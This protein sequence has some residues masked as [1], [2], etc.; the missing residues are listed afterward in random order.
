MKKIILILLALFI[1]TGCSKQEEIENPIVTMTIKDYGDVIIELYPDKAYNTV[2]NF[3]NLTEDG[4]YDNNT[5]HRLAKR[6]VLQGGDPT[7]TGSGGPGYTIK[8]E[9]ALNGVNNDISH[10]KGII[11]MART[12][13]YNSAGSQ[14]FIVL[15]DS[16]KTSLDGRYAAF[17]KVIEG[18]DVIETIENANL[19]ITNPQAGTLKE[20]LTIEKVTVDTKGHKYKVEKYKD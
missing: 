10:T 7:G 9:F 6:F 16:A 8:G 1:F 20:L 18:M 19:E 12:E 2:A 13:D 3:V 14:F 17:G 15:D 4:F 5:I 11:S